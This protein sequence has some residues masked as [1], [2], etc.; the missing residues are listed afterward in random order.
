MHVWKHLCV[1]CE[2][3]QQKKEEEEEGWK[4]KERRRTPNNGG[5]PASIRGVA[6]S[7]GVDVTMDAV[8]KY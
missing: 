5:R 2:C 6:M 7:T 3:V 4:R 8:Y 1:L